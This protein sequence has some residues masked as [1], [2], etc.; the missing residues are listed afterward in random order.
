MLRNLL[1]DHKHVVTQLAAGFKESRKHIQ[2]E[3][4]IRGFLDRTLTS[5]LGIR[6]LVMH[7]LQL[8]E[9]KVFSSGTLLLTF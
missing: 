5:R 3:E 9:E 4:M 6:L 7:H 2:N 1:D 8:R